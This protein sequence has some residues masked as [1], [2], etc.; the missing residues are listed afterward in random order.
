[1]YLNRKLKTFCS[2]FFAILKSTLNFEHFEEKKQPHSLSVSEVIDSEIRV[3]SQFVISV[4]IC[5][6]YCNL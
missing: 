6:S 1:M 3:L 5:N 2:N 4:A